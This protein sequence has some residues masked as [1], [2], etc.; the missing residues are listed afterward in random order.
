MT[1]ALEQRLAA[2]GL[3]LPRPPAAVGSYVPHVAVGKLLVI[4]GQLPL[5]D[6]K[7]AVTGR[8]GAEVSLAQGQE[9]AQLCALNILAQARAACLGDLTRLARCVRLGGFVACTPE[10]TEHAQVLNG[11]S[12]LVGQVM[13]EA[14]KHARFAVGVVSLPLGAAVEIEAMFE[15]A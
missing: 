7:V 9:A 12:D 13:A 11:A 6:G 4:A 2:L 8:L 5:V 14:G 1:S 10:F 3:S 15:L